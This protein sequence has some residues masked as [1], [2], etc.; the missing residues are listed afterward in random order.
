MTPAR[1]GALSLLAILLLAGA[2]CGKKKSKVDL[3]LLSGHRAYRD[4]MGYLSQ[5]RLNDAISTLDRIHYSQDSIDEIEPLVRLA[6]ADAT[7]LKDTHLSYIDAR[8]LYLDFVTLYGD[9]P[10]APYAQTQAGLCALRQ[11]NHPSRDQSQTYDALA[12]LAEVPRRYPDSPYAEIART[13]QTTARSNLAEAEF[14]VGRFY[15]KK[16]RNIAALERFRRVL[17]NYPDY[18]ETEKILFYM[19]RTLL[20]M[21]STTKSRIYLGQLLEDYPDSP[22]A[23]KGKKLL[24]KLPDPPSTKGEPAGV[25]GGEGD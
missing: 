19:G 18:T 14:L 2:G 23:K 7:F 11:V 5:H 13:L 3:R 17:D 10:L 21:E 24:A 12:D 9:H 20:R 22:Y 8:A 16:K 1:I 25:A 6:V 4:G 15:A